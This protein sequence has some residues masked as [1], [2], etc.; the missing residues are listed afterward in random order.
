MVV[1]SLP[2]PVWREQ[3]SDHESR[4]GARVRAAAARRER[5]EADPVED[6]LWEYYGVRPGQLLAYSAGVGVRLEGPGAREL[7][8][9]RGFEATEGGAVVPTGAYPERRRPFLAWLREL[10]DGIAARP[11]FLGCAGMH[12]WAMLYRT[13][14]PRHPQVP[15][16]VTAATLESTLESVGLAC[17]HF[18]ASRFFTAAALPL[19]PSLPTRES[20][21]ELE[22]K[23]CL[24]T[25]MDL[26]KW[27]WKLFP[28]SSSELVA[29]T[30]ELALRIREV[31]MRASP[32]DLS[33]RNL[34]PIRVETA[35][36]RREYRRWQERFAR[37]AEP[38][39]GR[40][41]EVVEGLASGAARGD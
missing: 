37:E 31:D 23:G 3:L 14:T 17:T 1:A 34:E 10:L 15:L 41:S 7:L 12:E 25:N 16:R 24:H 26:F 19:H 36:G 9:R 39:R 40:L 38:L 6:F 20:T 28:W 27:A 5:G 11:A 35:E 21:R 2:E 4:L 8:G 22:Q 29:D 30:F 18:D 13:D 32:Y 33:A